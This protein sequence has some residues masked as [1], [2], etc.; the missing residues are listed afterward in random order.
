[1][2]KYVLIIL[3]ILGIGRYA[4]GEGQ[5]YIESGP[6]FGGNQSNLGIRH[7]LSINSS[8]KCEIGIGYGSTS[9]GDLAL[10]EV[11]LNAL[12]LRPIESSFLH[13]TTGLSL[14]VGTT[15][16]LD[17]SRSLYYVP[18]LRAGLTSLDKYLV[19]SFGVDVN[20]LISHETTLRENVR[21]IS[22]FLAVGFPFY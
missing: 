22:P 4:Y 13:W 11:S 6:R 7:Q 17:A 2:G 16:R 19:V 18:S 3:A 12:A 1:M 21:D 9:V 10:R 20:F 5:F 14:G 8:T 15:E